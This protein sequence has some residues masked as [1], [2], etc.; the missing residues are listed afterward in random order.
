MIFPMPSQRR[1]RPTTIAEIGHCPTV[2]PKI[3]RCPGVCLQPKK[4]PTSKLYLLIDHYY[5]HWP[6]WASCVRI[7]NRYWSSLPLDSSSPTRF[8]HLCTGLV[9]SFPHADDHAPTPFHAFQ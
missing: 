1:F 9:D 6:A 3:P 8:D 2:C 5:V 7:S 4:R